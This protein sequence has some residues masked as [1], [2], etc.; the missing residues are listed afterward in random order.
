MSNLLHDTTK[1]CNFLYS[2]FGDFYLLKNNDK[3]INF[4]YFIV[5]DRKV[6]GYSPLVGI[7]TE[8]VSKNTDIYLNYEC[9]GLLELISQ[10]YN[11]IFLFVSHLKANGFNKRSDS[12]LRN[13]IV[14]KAS[15]IV[16]FE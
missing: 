2:S 3:N 12:D 14:E 10:N 16:V 5:L 7:V 9:T 15:N 6:F 1:I 4:L 8:P 13:F 11:E